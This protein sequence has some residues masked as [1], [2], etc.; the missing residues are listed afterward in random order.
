MLPHTPCRQFYISH[1]HNQP[2]VQVGCADPCCR[3]WHWQ[4]C[5]QAACPPASAAATPPPAHPTPPHPAHSHTHTRTPPLPR[6]H[7]HHHCH[8]QGNYSELMVVLS[9]VFSQ[10]RGD[11]LAEAQGGSA[12]VGGM[13]RDVR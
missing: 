9:G 13:R 3:A 12:Q 10:L 7:Y 1:L 2:W 5:R 8:L 4:C 11:Q 6:F